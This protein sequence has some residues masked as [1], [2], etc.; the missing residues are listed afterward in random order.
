MVC[1]SRVVSAS[2]RIASFHPTKTVDGLHHATANP[3]TAQVAGNFH[4]QLCCKN[5]CLKVSLTTLSEFAIEV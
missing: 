4:G 1:R 3:S 2:R 5:P